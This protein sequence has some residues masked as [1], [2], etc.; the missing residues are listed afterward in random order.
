MA[1]DPH[2]PDRTVAPGELQRCLQRVFE[3]LGLDGEDAG[4]LAGL[5]LDSELRGHRDHGVA[6]V[7]ILGDFYRGGSLNPRPQVRVVRETRGALLLHGDR[8]CGPGAPARAMQWCIDRAREGGGVAAAALDAWQ[9]LVAGPSVRRAA[10]AGVVGFACTNFAPLVAPP[11]GR[12][13]VFGTN[14]LAYG[15]PTRRHPPVVLD[16]ST[17]TSSM[18]KVRLAAEGGSTVPEGIV[19]DADGEAAVDPQAL[20]AGGSLAPLG[21]PLVPHKG[22][23]LAL[24]VDALTGVLSGGRFAREVE[25]GPAACFF[26]ALDPEWFLPGGEFAAR[27]DEQ[28]DQVKATPVRA[29]CSEIVVPGEGGERLRQQRIAQDSIPISDASWRLLAARCEELD[30]A[31]PGFR[32]DGPTVPS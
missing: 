4:P 31:L 22:F 12:S 32:S 24:L 14:P 30:V 20:F 25:R 6:A 15:L 16:M 9:L 7:G 28:I 18:Q 1:H 5:L 21:S 26:A 3:R 17:S 2:G 23:G 10:E 8:G 13:A 19:L 27:M 11:G 29:G